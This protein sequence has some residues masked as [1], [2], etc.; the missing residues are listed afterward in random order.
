MIE[1]LLAKFFELQ[2]LK[3]HA[4]V[5]RRQVANLTT[6]FILL[7]GSLGVTK[8]CT[9]DQNT[10]LKVILQTSYVPGQDTTSINFTFQELWKTHWMAS[11]A[12][13]FINFQTKEKVLA[14]EKQE[15]TLLLLLG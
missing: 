10:D 1:C 14:N 13:L 7:L 12:P 8:N 6:L 2:R 15:K 5:K 11:F 9:T 4:E 3:Q